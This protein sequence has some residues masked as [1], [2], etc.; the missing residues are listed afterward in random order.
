[1]AGVAHLK[2]VDQLTVE[3]RDLQASYAERA[4]RALTLAVEKGHRDV[5]VLETDPELESVRKHLE[6]VKLVEAL[7]GRT[8]A[9][10]QQP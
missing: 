6:F 9:G 5:A 10:S 3:D 4:I 1:M 7:K 8:G 2:S